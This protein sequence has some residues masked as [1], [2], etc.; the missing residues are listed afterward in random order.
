MPTRRTR[1]RDASQR[2][3]VIVDIATGEAEDLVSAT[4]RDPVSRR[5]RRGGL[6][7]GKARA[8]RLTPDRRAEIARI[9]AETRWKKGR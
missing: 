6:K 9:A 4:K 5:G 7:G 1:P 2:A 8:E 3:K